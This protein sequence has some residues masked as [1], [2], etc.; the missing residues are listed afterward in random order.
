M[1]LPSWDTDPTDHFVL[2]MRN[3]FCSAPIKLLAEQHPRRLRA[4]AILPRG[5][6]EVDGRTAVELR[7]TS[8][9]IKRT[10]F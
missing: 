1:N 4:N 3:L 7:W 6:V 10:D 5:K 2:M 8:S 9:S